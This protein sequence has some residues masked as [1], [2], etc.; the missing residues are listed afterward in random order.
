[1]ASIREIVVSGK[2]FDSASQLGGLRRSFVSVN[3][4]SGGVEQNADGSTD[5]YFGPE[6][7]TGKEKNWV[8]TV[9]GKGFWIIL[10]L[11]APLEPWFDKTWRPS[12]IVKLD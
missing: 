1:M 5:V 8:Q 11:Y 7:L 9:P 10:R 6:A 2:C 3:N 4:Q 12:V